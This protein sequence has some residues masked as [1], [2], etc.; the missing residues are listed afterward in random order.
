MSFCL[1]GSA[2]GLLFVLMVL[3]HKLVS[4]LCFF[5]AIEATNIH[6]HFSQAELIVWVDIVFLKNTAQMQICWMSQLWEKKNSDGDMKACAFQ[7]TT[8]IHRLSTE[9]E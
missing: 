6:I 7:R 9:T 3:L 1:W 4:Q 2:V 8:I 5:S